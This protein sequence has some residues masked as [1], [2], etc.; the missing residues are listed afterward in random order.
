MQPLHR[1]R[2]IGKARD[3]LD[4]RVDM[5]ARRD[6]GIGEVVA[7]L[8]IDARPHLQD[9]PNGHAVISAALQFGQVSGDVIVQRLDP[10]FRQRTADQQRRD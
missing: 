7:F 8:I 2:G 5:I 9:L 6:A 10:P 3:I 4:Q 1:P